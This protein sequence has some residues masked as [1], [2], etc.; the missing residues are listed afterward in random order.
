MPQTPPSS[1]RAYARRRRAES[2]AA[3]SASLRLWSRM[4]EDF[5]ASYARIALP[6]LMV[7]YAAQDRVAR[8]A[9]DYVPTVLAEVGAGVPGR[10]FETFPEAW[11]G[12]T[13]DGRSV[14]GLLERPVVH[15]KIAVAAGASPAQALAQ[16]GSFLSLAMGTL[17]SDTARGVEQVE[18]TSRRVTSYVRMLNPPSC[19]RCIILAGRRYGMSEAF[20]RH[21]GCDCSHIPAPESIAGD[22]LVDPREYLDSLD[23]QALAR[24]LGSKANAAAYREHGADPGQLINAYRKRGDVRSAQVYGQRVKYTTEGT[25]RRGLAH[26]QM[27]QADY[28]KAQGERLGARKA[29]SRYRAPASLRAPRLM[30]S[31]IAQIATDRADQARLLKLYGWVL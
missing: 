22:M 16:A 20:D 1:A 24:A 19:G 7:A 2:G 11:V 27:A 26:H 23:D 17:L 25:T 18:A 31:S 28:V 8:A 15:A 5:D 9:L 3:V 30:P 6:L 4:G 13:G 29:G 14:V 10:D 12:T 21:N